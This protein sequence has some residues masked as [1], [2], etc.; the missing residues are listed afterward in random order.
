MPIQ[1]FLALSGAPAF[2]M[3]KVDM[4]CSLAK[5]CQCSGELG[6]SNELIDTN[7]FFGILGIYEL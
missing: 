5:L 1:V 7:Y 2:W 6:F 4:E 3:F